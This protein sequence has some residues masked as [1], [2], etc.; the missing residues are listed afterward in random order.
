[1]KKNAIVLLKIIVSFGIFAYIFSKADISHLWETIKGAEPLYFA[2]AIIVYLLIQSLSAYRWYLLLKPLGMS[3][4]YPKLLSYYFLGMYFSNFLPTAI[5]GDLVRI[6]YLNKQTRRLSGATASVFL[7]RDFG[8]AALL[9]IA[10]T[11]AAVAGTKFNGVPL[12]AAFA[13]VAIAF[14]A[15][16]LALFYRPSYNLLHQLLSLLKLKKVDEKV[17]CLLN[18][19]NSY[20]GHWNLIWAITALSLLIQLGCAV[21]NI[22][23]ARA[24]GLQTS[25]GWLDFLVL[26]PATGLISMVPLSLNGM[27]WR[28]ASYVVLF[29]AVGAKQTQ[30]LTL[31]LLW[32]GVLVLTSLPGGIIYILQGGRPDQPEQA[33]DRGS[34][35][36]ALENKSR[37]QEPVSTI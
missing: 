36:L 31:A 10:I 17:E 34:D 32:L 23:N 21:V 3:S 35:Q 9:F 2:A 6:Y 22:L 33:L 19:F 25:H 4:S 16:N 24:I 27:G 15:A 26:I 30:A 5:G 13:I 37:E 1:M 8:M 20:R 14:I 11:S 12:A 28:E 7:D 18:S 29:Q